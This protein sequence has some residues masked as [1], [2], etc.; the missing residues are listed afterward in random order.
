MS[1]DKRQF[2]IWSLI[3]LGL[4]L[5]SIVSAGSKYLAE[6][7]EGVTLSL[8]R[9]IWHQLG[10]WYS[11]GILSIL[12]TLLIQRFPVNSNTARFLF[13]GLLSIPFSALHTL[14]FY[15][16]S[17]P[18]SFF[19]SEMFVRTIAQRYPFD[20]IIF[21]CVIALIHAYRY[22]QVTQERE[23]RAT[24]MQAQLAEA[25]LQALRM[26]IQPHFLFN[27]LHSVS[28]MMYENVGSA[29]EMITRL[30]DLLRWSLKYSNRHEVTLDE[31]LQFLK[32]YV[33]I[34]KMRFG[35]RLNFKTDISVEARKA[36]VPNFILQP[37]VENA[38]RHGIEPQKIG[39]K[40]EIYARRENDRLRMQVSDN[41][42]GLPDRSSVQTSS[43]M[44]LSNCRDRLQ[45]LYDGE[46]TLEL[47]EGEGGGLTVSL[48][49]PFRTEPLSRIGI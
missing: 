7:S 25:Q 45:Q 1:S 3:F 9:V 35:E 36:F 15:L 6:T 31:E 29:H 12:F 21:L 18:L 28:A 22:F 26:Q 43:G 37:L 27:T 19:I 30:G 13:F 32:H 44:G 40:V 46:H 2:L 33:D 11:Y 23:L 34:Q 41:G 10:M 38:I 14:L 48:T 20:L 42:P 4:T 8:P 47:L 49:L 39:G 5:L 24:R 16:P 17:R